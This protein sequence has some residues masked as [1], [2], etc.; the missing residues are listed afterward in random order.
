[1]RAYWNICVCVCVC[2]RVCCTNDAYALDES[3]QHVFRV[4]SPGDGAAVVQDGW[5][6]IYLQKNTYH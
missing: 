6:T 3:S 5:Q 1:M 4:K 2:A